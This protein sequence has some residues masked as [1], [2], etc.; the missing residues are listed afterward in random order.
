VVRNGKARVNLSVFGCESR[1]SA[2]P[3]L[4]ASCQL[5]NQRALVRQLRLLQVD[6]A[7]IAYID[8]RWNETKKM[9]LPGEEGRRRKKRGRG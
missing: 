7:M 3:L 9:R 5:E 8:V 1:Q 2:Q 6:Q 4:T